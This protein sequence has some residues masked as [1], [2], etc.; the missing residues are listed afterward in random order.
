MCVGVC[1]VCVWV[2][3][4]HNPKQWSGHLDHMRKR[5]GWPVSKMFR[6][7]P[8]NA[9]YEDQF[10][11]NR[12][13]KIIKRNAE[14]NSYPRLQ[15]NTATMC[16]LPFGLRPESPPQGLR[17]YRHLFRLCIAHRHPNFTSF[18][19]EDIYRSNKSIYLTRGFINQKNSTSS[20]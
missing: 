5:R 15:C 14:T 17:L 1:V 2:L 19:H 18:R 10:I 8:Q 4:R 7:E 6:S 16:Y 3:R 13:Y 9:A 12:Y 20:S 11:Y